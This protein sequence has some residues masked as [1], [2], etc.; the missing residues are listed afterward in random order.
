MVAKDYQN[1]KFQQPYEQAMYYCSL[2]LE[3]QTW[4][5]NDGLEALPHLQADNLTQFFPLMLSRT[6]L[7]CYISGSY[8]TQNTVYH[9]LA[10]LSDGLLLLRK[11]GTK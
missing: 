11:H 1:F 4:P 5:W 9:V 8:I 10:Y 2:I 7:E 6:F 3:D